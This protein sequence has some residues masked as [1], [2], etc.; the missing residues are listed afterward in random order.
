MIA[1]EVHASVTVLRDLEDVDVIGSIFWWEFLKGFFQ[2][3]KFFYE[4]VERPLWEG[5]LERER[6]VKM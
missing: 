5:K 4:A 1:S 6:L 3:C 2:R